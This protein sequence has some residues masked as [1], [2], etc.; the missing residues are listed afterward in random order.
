MN[1]LPRDHGQF[2]DNAYW[3]RF[4]QKRTKAFEWYG[5]Y[6]E[7][8]GVIHKYV[9]P[10]EKVLIVGCGNSSL[11]ADLYDVGYKNQVRTGTAQALP[12]LSGHSFL[13][14]DMKLL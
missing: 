3:D 13:R 12:T 8:C 11:S 14:F 6:G 5:E 7:L 10:K 4:F 2:R 1:L 9:K